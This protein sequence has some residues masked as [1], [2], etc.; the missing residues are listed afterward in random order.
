MKIEEGSKQAFSK[1]RQKIL[2]EAFQEMHENGITTHYTEAPN[3]GLWEGYRLIA[4]D[5]STLRLP[6]SDELESE[7]GLYPGKEITRTIR[8]NSRPFHTTSWRLCRACKSS[9]PLQ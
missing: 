2:P 7:F 3:K 5:G 9:P 1:A 6:S 4:A 8:N